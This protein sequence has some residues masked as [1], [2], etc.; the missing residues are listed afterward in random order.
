MTAYRP[1]KEQLELMYSGMPEARTNILA[2]LKGNRFHITFNRPKRYN[3]FSSD[4][5]YTFTSLIHYANQ[6][7]AAKFIIIS[8]AGGNFSSGNDLMNFSNTAITSLGTNEQLSRVSAEGLSDLNEAIINSK[9][10]IFAITEGKV[11]GF[12][13]TQLALYDRVFSVTNSEF[14]AP[15]VKLAQGPEMCA[16]F[17]FPKIFGRNVGEDLLVKGS[18]VDAAFL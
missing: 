6:D 16:S 1:I 18:K 2:E 5:Y 4:M 3:A 10:P 13:F 8:G 14:N 9:K 17:T 12:A 7:D 11:I 15:L